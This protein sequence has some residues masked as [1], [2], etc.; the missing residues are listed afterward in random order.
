MY[1]TRNIVN[2]LYT[3]VWSKI[4][5]NIEQLGC[6]SETNIILQVNYVVQ[7]LIYMQLFC[8]P[9]TQPTRLLCPW[10]FPGKKAGVGCHFLL[11]YIFQEQGLKMCL[12]CLLHYQAES[13]TTFLSHQ[14]NPQVTIPQLKKKKKVC[15]QRGKTRTKI[16]DRTSP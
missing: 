12:M 16:T 2:I 8:D 13:F 4:Y 1:S 6:T 15:S 3:F 5:K 10:D 9:L 14:G 7:S 11:Q